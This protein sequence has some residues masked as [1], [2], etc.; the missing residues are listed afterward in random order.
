MKRPQS[1]D[2]MRG[3]L[4]R[5]SRYRL[6]Q[7]AVH[8][9]IDTIGLRKREIVDLL[10]LRYRQNLEYSEGRQ[11]QKQTGVCLTENRS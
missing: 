5:L 11:I 8:F 7:S 4:A 6:C 10:A 2:P 1:N 3:V 9:G